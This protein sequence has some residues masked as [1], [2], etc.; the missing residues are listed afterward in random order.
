MPARE[1]QDLANKVEAENPGLASELRQ[2]A[3]GHEP[4][5]HTT[6]PDFA[7]PA[8]ILAPHWRE[9]AQASAALMA[10]GEYTNAAY[11]VRTAREIVCEAQKVPE[12]AA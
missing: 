9:V 11:A 10:S 12:G 7:K 5:P 3:Q 6:G 4:R 2:N 1:F 8:S